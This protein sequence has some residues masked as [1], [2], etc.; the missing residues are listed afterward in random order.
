MR[1]IR[2]ISS[3]HYSYENHR[4]IMTLLIRLAACCVLVA[5]ANALA[6][7]PVRPVRLVVPYAPGGPTDIVARVVGQ[8]LA[9]DFGQ[10][11]LVD[12]RPGAGGLLGADLVAKSAPDGHT[13][14]LCSSGPMAV[15]PALGQKMPY[16]PDRDIAPVSLVV[17]IPYVLLVP[18]NGP[19]DVKE[20]IA[21]ARRNPGKLNFGS[22]GQATTSYFAAALFASMAKIDMA[23]VPYKGSSQAGSDLAGGHVQ[24]MFEAIPAALP[25]VKSG[26][27]R[28]LGVSTL[29][30]FPLLPDVPSIAETAVPGYESSTWSGIC[31][32]ARTEGAIVEQLSA[33]IRK[34]VASPEI[35]ERFTALGAATVANTPR[36]FAAFIAADRAKWTAIAQETGTRAR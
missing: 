8:K 33:A 30:R 26:K 9:E 29:H 18:A 24:M 22:A 4:G 23:H 36:E 5:A 31:A 32:P 35:Q 3:C 15:S 17:T 21:T 20:L 27:A 13:L 2:D 25:L 12:N 28:M 16:D 14:L 1:E 10:S 19:A 7:Y 6:A 34:A 11:V